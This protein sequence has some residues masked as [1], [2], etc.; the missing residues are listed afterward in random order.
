MIHLL[1]ARRSA[2][3]SRVN[4]VELFYDLVFV[5]A[6]T[7]LSHSLLH[8]F[9]VDGLLKTGFLTLAVWW[10]WMYTTWAMNWLDPHRSLVKLMLFVMM[11][12]G[13][14]MSVSIPEAFG[15][16]GLLFA[17]AFV[18]MQVG[19][20]LFMSFVMRKHHD[21]AHF[22]NFVRLTVWAGISAVFWIS[23]GFSEGDSRW[24]LWGIAL[25]VE[26]LGPMVSF[27]LP[28]LGVSQTADWD[29][30]GEHMAER[31][32]LFMIIALGES[33]LVTGAT[34]AESVWT[35]VTILAFLI[36]FVSTVAMWWVYFNIM[37]EHAAAEIAKAKDPG[38]IGR[39][40]YTYM[41]IPLVMGV[42]LTAVGDELV[43]AHPEGH[44][45]FLTA[46]A[47]VGGPLIFLIGNFPFKRSVFRMTA[48]Y[49][50]FGI[51]ATA[52]LFGLYQVVSPLVLVELVTGIMVVVGVWGHLVMKRSDGIGTAGH[53]A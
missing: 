26:Y 2:E 34:F 40:A 9:D 33:L 41:H 37:A 42:I 35:N 3:D 29:I 20:S 49:H 19:R 13:L 24:L 11:L 12:A 46:L 36:T 51:V 53:A 7:Q 48:P 39:L 17:S 8:H 4:F 52:A 25:V 30:S 38:R 43:L 16:R 10:T 32:G 1:R 31:C 21:R 22:L 47:I 27:W 44:T 15:E 18:L 45:E 14:V 23:G 28:G 5:F 6:I 50:V